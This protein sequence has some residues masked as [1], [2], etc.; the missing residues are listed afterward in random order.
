MIYF[1]LRLT[2]PWSPIWKV[3]KTISGNITKNKAWELN[4]YESN[5]LIGI[6]FEYTMRADHA[7]IGLTLSLFGYT[8]EYKIYDVRHWDYTQ[9]KWS[10]ITHAESSRLF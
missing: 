7:G 3:L 10:D 8:L 1:K 9:D 2:N 6:E 4:L 5:E